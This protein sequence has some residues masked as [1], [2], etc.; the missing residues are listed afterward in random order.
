LQRAAARGPPGT[1]NQ[2]GASMTRRLLIGLVL[3]AL[4]GAASLDAQVKGSPKAAASKMVDINNAAETDIAA[5]GIDKA[6]AKKII[7]GRPYRNKREL[8]SRQLLTMD[9]YDKLKDLIVAK[10]PMKK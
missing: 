7:E 10:Q 5:I 1:P 6:V 8:V 2:K 3:S 9:Q 4:V